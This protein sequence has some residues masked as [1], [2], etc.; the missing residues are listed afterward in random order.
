MSPT[1]LRKTVVGSVH[2]IGGVLLCVVHFL[3]LQIPFEGIPRPLF[4]S[5]F[6]IFFQSGVD[7]LQVFPLHLVLMCL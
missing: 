1:P 5:T 6:F 2:A 4:Y 3:G 7:A